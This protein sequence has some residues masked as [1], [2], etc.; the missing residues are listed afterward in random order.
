[1][2]QKAAG[3]I[4]Q[5]T[6]AL[7]LRDLV[8]S[9][10]PT[11]EKHLIHA[12]GYGSG[13]F[14]QGLENFGN[15]ATTTTT[16]PPGMLDMI[17][18]VRDAQA[19]HYANQLQNA[20]HYA[21][22]LR[23]LDP[24]G[25]CAAGIQRSFFGGRDGKVLFHVIQDPVPL[26]YG[27]IQYQDFISDLIHWDSLYVAGRLHKPTLTIPIQHYDNDDHNDEDNN[28]TQQKSIQH[29]QQIN[30]QAAAAAAMLLSPIV[31]KRSE[32]NDMND[33]NNIV[34]WL[35]LYTQIAALSYTGDFRMKVGGE[36]PHKI[37]KLVETP[38]QLQRFHELYRGD[39]GNADDDSKSVL[40]GWEEMG[41]ISIQ[42]DGL[43]WDN[44]DV[45]VRT[46]LIQSLPASVQKHVSQIPSTAATTITSTSKHYSFGVLQQQQKGLATT[47][48]SIV[49]PAAKYQSFKGLFTFGFKNSVRYAGAKLSKGLGSRKRF[50]GAS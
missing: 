3:S 1:M 42:D 26:K 35:Q 43:H 48:K 14:S 45:A 16:N 4:G 37:Q 32:I 11:P 12:F 20:S 33:D 23:T 2:S 15:A 21:T 41:M 5:L 46:R 47:L 29:A 40:K 18:V 34:S 44:S 38:G 9:I 31:R 22:W 8:H 28:S 13:V 49:A 25:L 36:D 30:L 27:V 6:S 39:N 17:L 24:Q 7:K 19:W 50:G 10:F